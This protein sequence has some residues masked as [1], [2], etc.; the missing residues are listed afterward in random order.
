MRIHN[1]FKAIQTGV[2]KA[3]AY[4]SKHAEKV[5]W[6]RNIICVSNPQVLEK[7]R[8]Y[9]DSCN[10]FV[11]AKAPTHPINNGQIVWK[12]LPKDPRTG[13]TVLRY[14]LINGPQEL[15]FGS[16]KPNLV[17][18][19]MSVIELTRREIFERMEN[20]STV[21]HRNIRF[22]T[23]RA[24]RYSKSWNQLE[25]D[26]VK[27]ISQTK[28]VIRSHED[29]F[30]MALKFAFSELERGQTK[31][32]LLMSHS[33]SMTL[34]LKNK[35]GK[36][37]ASL[38]NPNYPSGHFKLRISDLND[39]HSLTMYDLMNAEEVEALIDAPGGDQRV[40]QEWQA[41]SK[42]SSTFT[43]A[44]IPNG[45]PALTGIGQKMDDPVEV[46][47]CSWLRPQETKCIPYQTWW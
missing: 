38:W 5:L 8:N 6:G 36:Y 34:T 4:I 25:G 30:G 17:C 28:R 9:K 15:K 18:R 39:C 11:Y 16:V 3:A 45:W 19:H 47:W 33:H 24:E 35:N 21:E 10:Y 13:E 41:H 43:M 14:E 12:N 2:A 20:V 29:E 23:G 32:F 42:C 27:L 44:E 22:S 46:I 37:S 26:F 31:N 1:P 7:Y 40:F